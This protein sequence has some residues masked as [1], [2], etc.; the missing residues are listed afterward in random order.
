MN[1]KVKILYL[2]KADK[3]LAKNPHVLSKDE[4]DTMILKSLKKIYKNE[5][6]NIDLKKL[7]T[8]TNYYRIRKGNVRI[9][10]YIN[11]NGEYVVSVI[12]S[13]GYR[14]DIYKK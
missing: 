14:G 2:K 1:K 4:I 11:D 6:I 5:N 3:F 9:I 7:A 12:E 8:Y 13:I 10:F